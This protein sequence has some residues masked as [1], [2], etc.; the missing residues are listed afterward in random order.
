VG[1]GACA[2]PP[3]PPS[4]P[5]AASTTAANQ[6]IPPPA[7]P[8]KTPE[9]LPRM[10]FMGTARSGQRRRT[11]DPLED[12]SDHRGSGLRKVSR[13]GRVSTRGSIPPMRCGGGQGS[14][15]KCAGMAGPDHVEVALVESGPNPS[16]SMSSALAALR[17]E[18]DAPTAANASLRRAPGSGSWPPAGR[19]P[20]GRRSGPGGRLQLPARRPTRRAGAPSAS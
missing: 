4:P 19:R 1:Q 20:P 12:S 18:V 11:R 14:S 2:P 3:G 17:P 6:A 16:A 7:P 9:Q 10:T 5:S 8:Q 13:R 15:S